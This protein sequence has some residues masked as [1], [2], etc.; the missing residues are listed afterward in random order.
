MGVSLCYTPRDSRDTGGVLSDRYYASE[1][2]LI[3]AHVEKSATSPTDDRARCD[4]PP[5]SRRLN[6]SGVVAKLW[7]NGEIAF[8]LPKK[9]KESALVKGDGI[10][11]NNIWRWWVKVYGIGPAIERAFLMG[12]SN[13]TNFDR[14][15]KA[16][17]RYGLRGISSLGKKRVRNAAY[18]LTR[19]ARKSRLTFSTVTV[20]AF[21]HEDMTVIHLNWHKII[22]R[23]RLLLS[24]HLVSG[25]LTG[26]IVGVSEI[27]E[28][29]YAHNGFP[30]LHGHFVFVGSTR[31]GRWVVSPT[32]HDCIWRKAIQSV[33]F[34]P[35]PSFSSAC[36]L[37]SVKKDA[38]GYLGKYV[39]KG[40][41]AIAS[42]VADG[43]EWAL[44]KQWWSCSRSL[45]RKME[46]EI[47]RFTEGVPWLIRTGSDKD[48]EM[49]DFYYVVY[50]EGKEGQKIEVGAAGRLSAA[51]NGKI[52]K[53][54][55]IENPKIPVL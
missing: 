52:R 6:K 17:L 53:F 16:P 7:P 33:L 23:Y 54:L 36:Q 18:L 47:R 14:V 35:L 42:V 8:H 22:D 46:V 27:Q 26:E 51:A 3:V 1:V 25:G 41:T 32:T 31:A 21:H 13:V 39:S 38:A 30:V 49:W 55:G 34:G 12:L 11:T 2:Y 48:S 19:E 4:R 37:Q 43:F 15:E 9:L 44:P 5:I 50:F 45:T 28:K 40:V 29:R 10:D 24:R 20:P